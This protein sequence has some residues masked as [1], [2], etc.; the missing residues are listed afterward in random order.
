MI[1]KTNIKSR[2]SKKTSPELETTIT[3]ALKHKPW[4][5]VAKILSGPTRYFSKVNLKEIDKQSK[6]GDTIIIPGKVL[7]SGDLTKQLTLVALSISKQA[8]DKL[9]DSKSKFNTI[10]EEIKSNSKAE[11][12]KLIK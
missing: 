9:K 12:V 6:A 8:Q 2:A 1:S 3:E 11:G 4:H 5:Q 7:S 10:A